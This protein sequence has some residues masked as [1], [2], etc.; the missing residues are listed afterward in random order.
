ML[1]YIVGVV[2]DAGV[3]VGNW[4]RVNLVAGV[5]DEV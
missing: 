1:T 5:A 2:H 3:V 4:E